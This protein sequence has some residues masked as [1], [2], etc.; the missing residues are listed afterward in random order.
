MHALRTLTIG[1]AL[2]L[3]PALGVAE[4]APP[5][6]DEFD[7]GSDRAYRRALAPAANDKRLNA[8]G[9]ATTRLRRIA[10]RLVRSAGMIDAE[11]QR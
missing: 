9:A 6:P 2:I 5:T 8:D 11:S 3:L 10:H 4:A 1:L 7:R